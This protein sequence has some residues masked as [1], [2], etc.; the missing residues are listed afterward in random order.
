MANKVCDLAISVWV[1][2]LSESCGQL[3]GQ[4]IIKLRFLKDIFFFESKFLKLRYFK[5]IYCSFLFMLIFFIF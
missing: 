5:D 2:D 4:V 3:I 1:K